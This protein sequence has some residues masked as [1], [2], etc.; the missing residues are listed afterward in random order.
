MN[1]EE[2]Y[3]A[4][5]DSTTIDEATKE[6][7]KALTD[8]KE[9]EDRFYKNLEFGTGGLRGKIA[10][11][12]NRMNPYTVGKATQGLATY[13]VKNFENPSTAIAYDQMYLQKQL[14]EY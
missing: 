3:K 6:E 12:T 2:N 1:F 4:W 7:L 10:A 9:I 11:G 5:L 13:L 8:I 14:L